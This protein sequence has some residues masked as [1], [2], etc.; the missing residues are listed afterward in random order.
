MKSARKYSPDQQD[1][2]KVSL[3]KFRNSAMSVRSRSNGR[4]F[5]SILG[6]S[7]S[8]SCARLGKF[9]LLQAEKRGRIMAGHGLTVEERGWGQT[10]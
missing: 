10:S 2:K 5:F 9:P 8:A 7:F 1:A 3:K 6:V 4:L